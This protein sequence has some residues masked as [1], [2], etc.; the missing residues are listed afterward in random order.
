MDAIIAV[1]YKCGTACKTCNT[2]MLNGTM[3]FDKFTVMWDKLTASTEITRFVMNGL[4]DLNTLPNAI[5]YLKYME[6][7]RRTQPIVIT[8][9]C[10]EIPY[11]PKVDHYICS[12]NGGTKEAFEYTTGLPFEKVRD[13]IRSHY[14]DFVSKVGC[15]EIHMCV[16]S[17]NKGTEQAFGELWKDFPGRVRLNY[18]ATNIPAKWAASEELP[19]SKFPQCYCD[20]LEVITIQPNGNVELC[21]CGYSTDFTGLKAA[22]TFGNIFEDSFSS[23]INHPD[24]IKYKARQSKGIYDHPCDKCNYNTPIEGRLKYIKG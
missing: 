22:P 6:S 14:N 17:G 19:P 18:R 3:P 21:F 16:W 23:L 7:H 11:V 20:N 9:N 2:W 13:N 15:A 1:T 10:K 12:F 5:D 4:G 24:R 8:T